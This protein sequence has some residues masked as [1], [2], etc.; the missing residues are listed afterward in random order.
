M[1]I[2]SLGWFTE[3]RPMIEACLNVLPE[4]ERMVRTYL[5]QM[6]TQIYETN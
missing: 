6:Y 1:R 3:R 4:N 2:S 5:E